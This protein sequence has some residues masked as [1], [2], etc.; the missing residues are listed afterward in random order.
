MLFMALLIL[1]SNEVIYFN[2]T[3]MS[4]VQLD[5]IQKWDSLKTLKIDEIKWQPME[6]N[7][8]K[9]KVTAIINDFNISVYGQDTLAILTLLPEDSLLSKT[10]WKKLTCFYMGQVDTSF[11]KK[12]HSII[13]YGYRKPEPIEKEEYMKAVFIE[14]MN[15]FSE[16]GSLG[17]SGIQISILFAF[18]SLIT[19]I[20]VITKIKKH[21]KN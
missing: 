18:T 11:I 21:G 5:Y 7:K 14:N 2:T 19:T 16:L 1:Y 15:V 3:K 12:G 10:V 8:S 20:I 13:V 6:N 4:K 9:I 17:L